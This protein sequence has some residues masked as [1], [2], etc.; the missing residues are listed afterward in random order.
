MVD[1]IEAQETNTQRF[2]DF[3]NFVS[4]SYLKKYTKVS[5]VFAYNNNLLF[6]LSAKLVALSAWTTGILT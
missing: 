1:L 3:S 5:N 2:K 4:H 6:S